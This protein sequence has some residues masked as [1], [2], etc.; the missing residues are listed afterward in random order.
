MGHPCSWHSS[1]GLARKNGRSQM[2]HRAPP[3]LG[4]SVKRAGRGK[5]KETRTS[6]FGG[7][8]REAAIDGQSPSSL[9][10]LG[11]PRPIQGSESRS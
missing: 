9:V 3:L 6:R 5:D 1:H 11:S 2:L 8:R 10:G 4:P 7:G